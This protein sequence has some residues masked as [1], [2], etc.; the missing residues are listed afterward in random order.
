[1]SGDSHYSP[2]MSGDNREQQ[3]E[4]AAV[5]DSGELGLT[6]QEPQFN[7]PV[8]KLSEFHCL[9]SGGLAAS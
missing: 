5:I 8:I 4:P 9:G 7:W 6:Y 2:T 3:K 1:M